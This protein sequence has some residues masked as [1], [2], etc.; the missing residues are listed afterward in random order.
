LLLRWNTVS[1]I[2]SPFARK[3]RPNARTA[4]GRRVEERG[5]SEGRFVMKRIGIESKDNITLAGN[6]ADFHKVSR[7][8]NGSRIFLKGGK[9]NERLWRVRPPA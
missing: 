6:G 4:E 3:G 5:E 7:H 2:G 1:P 9:A 8:E